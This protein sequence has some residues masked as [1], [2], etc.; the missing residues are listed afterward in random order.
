MM[1]NAWYGVRP[2]VI[3]HRVATKLP[4]PSSSYLAT[5]GMV[6]GGPTAHDPEEVT[7]G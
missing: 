4:H 1:S 5:W 6:V 7:A 3:V 2:R